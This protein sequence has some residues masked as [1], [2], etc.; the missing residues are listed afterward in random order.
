[1]I[2]QLKL[3]IRSDRNIVIAPPS[4]HPCGKL[5]EFVNPHV[6][7]ILKI[8]NLGDAIWKKAKKLRVKK[9]QPLLEEESRELQGEP[10]IGSDPPCMQKLLEGVEKGL[11]NEAGIRLASYWMKFK[12][13]APPQV[14]EKLEQW[15]AL[16]KPP[17]PRNEL[18]QIAES[19]KKLNRSFGCRQ[20]QAWC[21]INKCSL[22]RKQLLRK[23]A[24]EE[25][26]KILNSPDVLDALKP[27]LDNIIAGEDEN[28]QLAFTLLLSGKIN[29]PKLKQIILLK[30]E[31]GA[32]KTT[33]MR[34]ADAFKT[35]SV[36]RFTPHALDYSNLEDYE[37]L[38][39]KEIGNMDQ[40][41]QGVSTIKFLSG[42]DKGYTVEIPVR[43]KSTGRFASEQY[44]VPP[45]TL[46]TSTTRVSMDKQF[47]RRSWT[48]N[49]DETKEQ[50][51]NIRQMK[52]KRIRD[53]G[54]VKLGLQKQ[55]DYDQS[56]RV[57]KTV[58][59]ILDPQVGIVLI[60]QDS[61]TKCL[62][63]EK[64]R[65]R[66]D[67]DKIIGLV[68]LHAF[69]HQ[70]TLPKLKGADDRPI[71]FVTPKSALQALKTAEKPFITMTTELEERARRLVKILEDRGLSEAGDEITYEIRGE[72]AVELGVSDK[73]VYRYLMEW[74]K[75]GY[76]SK[77]K[78]TSQ[79]GHPVTFHLL[80]DLDHI[81][82][83][84]AVSLDIGSAKT[85]IG[86]DMQKEIE[87]WLDQ[88]LDK[89]SLW[90]GWS[91][92]K[93]REALIEEAVSPYRKEFLSK[94]ETGKEISSVDQMKQDLLVAS[95]VSKDKRID[96]QKKTGSSNS[97]GNIRCCWLCKK[98]V[99]EDLKY[100]TALKG[101]PVHLNCFRKITKDLTKEVNS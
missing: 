10:Y 68:Q 67:Y 97:D 92:K 12:G 73:T 8:E 60:F 27:H 22:K 87:K 55:T 53:D 4:K 28:K 94:E 52:I 84:K 51:E 100:T 62:Q 96:S 66:G 1:M 14:L 24:E 101:K 19:A 72:I 46:I 45:I 18:E 32:G 35:K 83:M 57:L 17:I 26:E 6:K 39:L 29:D 23:E 38:R 99:P 43:D 85:E 76:M 77:F 95:P 79:K 69:L 21:N 25:A 63:S 78:D 50:T 56:I 89:I 7:Q 40:E 80:Y 49:P 16:N 41:F 71:V 42:D 54:L 93:V 30:G 70:R 59:K 91:R 44:R 33:L 5:Y 37:V 98:P 86:S 61:L 13:D 31:S 75:A 34:L 65:V 82:K 36:G 15:N 47:E 58:V 9:P 2:P 90:K 48:L 3:E 81:T 64:L 20:N 74:C 88:Y 11:R